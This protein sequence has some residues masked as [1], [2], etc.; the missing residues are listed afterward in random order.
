VSRANLEEAE[1]DA[2][3]KLKLS[4]SGIAHGLPLDITCPRRISRSRG[5]SSPTLIPRSTPF[6]D[7]PLPNDSIAG[8]SSPSAMTQV[9]M[10]SSMF[11]VAEE[12][13]V[14]VYFR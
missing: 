3:C 10:K 7:Q 6:S 1:L 12:S 14:V 13:E 2:T 4:G 8:L 11:D 5:L 9:L